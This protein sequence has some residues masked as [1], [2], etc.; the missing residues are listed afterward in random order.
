MCTKPSDACQPNSDPPVPKLRETVVGRP[1][2][3]RMAQTPGPIA[4]IA[5]PVLVGAL[6]GVVAHRIFGPKAGIAVVLVV[7]A[8][9]Q[10]FDQPATRLLGNAGL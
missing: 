2:T 9:H 7:L 4:K 5:G 1:Y 3:R 8:A 10:Y 6:A